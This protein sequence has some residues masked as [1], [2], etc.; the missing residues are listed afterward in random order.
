MWVLFN[1]VEFGGDVSSF[2]VS[3]WQVRALVRNH[4]FRYFIRGRVSVC[5]SKGG[6]E[7]VSVFTFSTFTKSCALVCPLWEFEGRG[8]VNV[9]ARD[10]A[11]RSIILF[12]SVRCSLA[13]ARRGVGAYIFTT[14]R[15]MLAVFLLRCIPWGGRI[16]EKGLGDQE[17][18]S[19][20]TS[21]ASV[22]GDR[23][24]QWTVGREVWAMVMGVVWCITTCWYGAA[25]VTASAALSLRGLAP[26]CEISASLSTNA[27]V[28]VSSASQFCLG[29]GESVDF[30]SVYI[31]SCISSSRL[32]SSLFCFLRVSARLSTLAAALVASALQTVGGA[33]GMSLEMD[34]SW[35][36]SCT[37]HP[38]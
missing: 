12:A 32:L 22:C 24:V 29:S 27:A 20:L 10:E 6:D 11:V 16:G 1:G 17:C 13:G 36:G 28:L 4:V 7:G 33:G 31:S 2:S 5:I 3:V 30:D 19:V 35:E 26:T 25:A 8:G 23:V 37:F 38:A 14:P 21:A 18:G 9:A 15:C 34:W